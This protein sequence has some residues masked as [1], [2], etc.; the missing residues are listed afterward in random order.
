MLR[1]VQTRCQVLLMVK[2][3]QRKLTAWSRS[4]STVPANT[5]SPTRTCST[6]IATQS[7]FEEDEDLAMFIGPAQD[8][9]LLEVGV[10]AARDFGSVVIAHAMRARPKHLD[11]L[12]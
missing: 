6:P 2:C 5:G 7:V 1:A 11:R 12:R 4:S 10:V 8:A 3:C 9:N